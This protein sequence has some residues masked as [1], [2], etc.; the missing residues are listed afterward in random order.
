MT[1]F[2]RVLSF[3]LAAAVTAN[4]TACGTAAKPATENPASDHSNASVMT[5]GDAKIANHYFERV[6]KTDGT[7]EMITSEKYGEGYKLKE[8]T[9][10]EIP[11]TPAAEDVVLGETKIIFDQIKGASGSGKVLE[12]EGVH[13]TFVLVENTG[14]VDAYVRTY[15]ALEYSADESDIIGF[16]VSDT[17]EWVDIGEVE[18]NDS[19][20]YVFELIYRGDSNRHADSIL[21]AGEYT[22]DNLGQF[23]IAKDAT[24]EEC[25]ALDGNSN[26]IY[27]ILILSQAVPADK[28]TD[29]AAALEA[30]FGKITNENAA[31]LF[32]GKK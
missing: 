24:K 1:T 22:F 7:F 23:Y 15:V 4:I 30:G 3:V 5:M 32:I 12:G 11:L 10:K 28:N 27:D 31:E 14:K 20:F 29:A 19:N 18:M 26:G 2:K 16:T 17:W 8:F 21:P 13:D 6:K 9:N 25:A